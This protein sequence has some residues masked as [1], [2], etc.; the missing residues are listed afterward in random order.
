MVT[1]MVIFSMG[2][3]DIVFGHFKVHRPEES[4]GALVDNKGFLL[5]G[6]FHSDAAARTCWALC[7]L[8]SAPVSV[9]IRRE[10]WELQGIR[11]RFQGR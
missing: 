9:L 7:K 8:K 3:M 11:G 2:N 4:R 1:T 10:P 5:S 6:A